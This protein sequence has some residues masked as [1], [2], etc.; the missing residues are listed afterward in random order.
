MIRWRVSRRHVIAFAGVLGSLSFQD[1]RASAQEPTTAEQELRRLSAAIDRAQAEVDASQRQVLELKRSLA[2][3]QE[4]LGKSPVAP[5]AVMPSAASMNA[6]DSSAQADTADQGEEKQ[7]VQQ[8]EL[9]TLNQIKVESSSKYPVSIHGLILFNGFLNTSAVDVPLA[10]SIAFSGAGT[11]G[12]SLRQTSFGI[13]ARGPTL[14]G[15]S[16]HADFDV[17]LLGNAAAPVTATSTGFVRLRTA[18]AAL[19]WPHTQAFFQFDRPILNPYSPTSLVANAQP[20]LAWSGNLWQWVPQVGITQSVALGSVRT[21]EISAALIDSPDPP[22]LTSGGTAVAGAA[23]RSRRPGG[24]LHLELAQTHRSSGASFG[25]GAYISPHSFP[26]T[27]SYNAWAATI[28]WRLPLPAGLLLTGNAY[29]GLALGGLGGGTYKD[30]ISQQGGSTP[31]SRPLDNTGGWTQ[32]KKQA[33]ER[34]EFN[35]AIGF[36]QAFAKELT[37]FPVSNSLFYGNLA[38]N[39]TV[40]GNVIWS[41]SAYLLFS[42]EYHRISSYS[43]T[44]PVANSN[45]FGIAAGYKF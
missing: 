23:E 5:E 19:D 20:A 22:A 31:A 4:R 35:G 10:P 8:T 27:G 45:V 6:P 38:R 2:S 26:N 32:L 29:R 24:E 30:V 39:R 28:D 14:A 3:L 44:L 17:D 16:S 37:A 36:D 15:A 1:R 13:D 12:A 21:L 9:A 33:G 42:F 11:A 40:T 41:P 25:V 34:L 43:T 18:H 7:A